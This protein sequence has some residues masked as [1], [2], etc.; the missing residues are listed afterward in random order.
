M[1]DY[2]VTIIDNLIS[3]QK[4][5]KNSILS[6]LYDKFTFVETAWITSFNWT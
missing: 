5:L 6:K 2:T 4:N 3:T 1:L